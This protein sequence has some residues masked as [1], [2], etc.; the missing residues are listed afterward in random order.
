MTQR[1]VFW[2]V[3]VAAMAVY[4]AIVLWSLP[5]IQSDANG[6]TPF[7]LRPVGY[8]F[9]EAQAFLAA[10]GERGRSQYLGP[11][12][13]LDLFYPGL[14]ALALSLGFLRLFP[15]RWAVGFSAIAI[16]AAVFDWREDALVSDMLETNLDALSSDL[17]S[18]ASLMTVLKSGVSTIAMLILC[19]GLCLA[20][21]RRMKGFV[22]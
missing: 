4:L 14:L 20:L 9:A 2:A 5:L 7:D 16:L 8:S 3:V 6:L 19:L 21:W 13:W 12:H 17:V 15:L 11:Q 18:Q 22:R 10:L 1:W